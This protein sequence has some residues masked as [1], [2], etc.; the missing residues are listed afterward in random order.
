MAQKI[1]VRQ[2][3]S[4]QMIDLIKE[5]IFSLEFPPGSRLIVD[6]LAEKFNSS[7]TPVREALKK[8]GEQGLVDYNG[9]GYHV[10]DLS[11]EDITDIYALRTPLEELAVKLAAERVTSEELIAMQ[12]I[13]ISHIKA[14]DPVDMIDLDIRFHQAL[15]GAS[16][17]TR[18]T[19]ILSSLMDQHQLVNRWLFSKRPH[20][21]M[22][23]ETIDEH[24]AILDGLKAHDASRT[25]KAMRTHLDHAEGRAMLREE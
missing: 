18:L 23:Q 9:K 7:R 3:I 5:A 17:C 25:V 22:E 13:M 20:M 2:S 24:L 6:T 10:I 19:R 21:P 12:D 8:L 15:A 11:P 4:D 1:I 14:S 16:H